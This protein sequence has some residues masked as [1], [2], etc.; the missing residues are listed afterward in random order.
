[1]LT[2]FL[3]EFLHAADE[4]IVLH[5]K[6]VAIESSATV[7]ERANVQDIGIRIENDSEQDVVPEDLEESPM[8]LGSKEADSQQD[9]RETERPRRGE[10]QIY[11]FFL[12][13]APKLLLTLFLILLGSA[14]ILERSTG[15]LIFASTVLLG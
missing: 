3:V 14:A 4:V 2:S 8:L 13:A 9:V 11:R 7:L 15:T 5:N 10:F 1:M 6:S 12:Q